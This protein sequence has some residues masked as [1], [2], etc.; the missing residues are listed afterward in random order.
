M[1]RF[2]SLLIVLLIQLPLLTFA[3]EGMWLLPLIQQLNIQKLNQMGLQ[4]TADD[5]YSINHSSLK[6]AVVALDHGSCTGELIS[7]DGLLLTNHHCGY[8]E[9]QLH[10]TV[11][12]DYL[13]NGFW[14]YK[15]DQE[16]VNP[17]KSVTFLVRMEDV[18]DQ[19]VSMLTYDMSEAQRE[20]KIHELSAEIEKKATDGNKYE[21]L[22]QSFFEGN[23]YYLLIYQTFKDI[24]LVG[25]PPSSIGKFGGD[26]D[27]WMWPR[28]TGD[29]SIFRIYC[30]PDGTPAEYSPNNVP[31][32]PA[33][34]LTVSLKGVKK[35]DYAMILG[36]PG[37]TDRYLT[38]AGINE[39]Q[40][41]THP[42]RILIR[43][44]KQDLWMKD[45]KESDKVRI[46]YADKF[47]VSSNYWKFSIGQMK[48][49]N[50]LN[51][52]NNRS[53]LEKEF[54]AWVAE[55]PD[56]TARYGNAL[57]LMNDAYAKR[58]EMNSATQYLME[59][60][61]SGV[62][63][64]Q[65]S[66]IVNRLYMTMRD[67]PDSTV[68]IKKLAD[69]I[70]KEMDK[71]YKDFNVPTD[72]KVTTA[73]LKLYY[74]K[75]PA[76]YHL[77][78]YK[79]IMKK[80]KGDYEK[81]VT[82]LYDKS[83]FTTPAKFTEFLD[84]PSAKKLDKDPV[85]NMTQAFL[86]T[87]FGIMQVSGSFDENLNRGKRLFLAG[88]MEMQKDRV[89]YPDANSTMRLTYGV[90][91]DYKPMDAVFYD[92]K[93]T[94]T[95]VM[96]KEDP[97]NDEFIVDPKLKDL[98]TKKDFGPYAENGDVPVCF[99]TNN[100]ITGGNSGSLVMNAKGEL[101][102]IAFDG[103]WEAMSGDI[104]YEPLIQKCICVDIRYVLFLIDKF[105]GA[106]NLIDEL[107]L[108]SN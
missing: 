37:N 86:S 21:A 29:F 4:L 40:E 33:K 59:A 75:V 94:L 61:Y 8:S 106:H 9:I 90:V 1:K 91:S 96:E 70:K 92:F 23:K 87:Y 72:K 102:G 20:A 44:I 55:N 98:Y 63:I 32:H 18:S 99:T 107:N 36:Y 88:L 22:V 64:M 17:D 97:K 6:D 35:G 81:Y 95:G 62:E 84:K 14:A 31:F 108:S 52:A 80:Y 83:I 77:S 71:F 45:M 13:T 30:A 104:Q 73:M 53:E 67:N 100:D 2:L 48:G 56:R 68:L 51:V 5:I 27:N 11:E 105:A 34:F 66:L 50:R 12:H 16:L 65:Y 15:R 78:I 26:T 60:F 103:N 89:F 49:L 69:D 93:T 43:G 85:F 74:D 41:V 46:Q 57:N 10:S 28:H 101:I 79:Q 76:E 38:S 54:T 19:I 47:S 39:L 3:D 7:A 25:A 24:R 82:D 58:K 42:N